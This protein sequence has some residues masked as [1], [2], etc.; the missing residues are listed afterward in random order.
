M[1]GYISTEDSQWTV[2]GFII[3]SIAR[4]E[5]V[6]SGNGM[7]SRLGEEWFDDYWMN[8]GKITVQTKDGKTKKITTLDD[9]VKYRGGDVDL[10][11]PKAQRRKRKNYE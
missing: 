6:L 4:I 8:F 3:G 11:V 9:F 1:G 2:K 10:I 5:D 7:F